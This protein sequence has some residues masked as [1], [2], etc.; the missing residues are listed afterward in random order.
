VRGRTGQK[1]DVKLSGRERRTV[2]GGNV[3]RKK[4]WELAVGV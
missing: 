1:D 4:R 3:A 2:G